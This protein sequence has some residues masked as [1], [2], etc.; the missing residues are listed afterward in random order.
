MEAKLTGPDFASS[1]RVQV[2]ACLNGILY[3]AYRWEEGGG[4]GDVANVTQFCELY[5]NYLFHP[6]AY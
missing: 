6:M 5:L 3:L 1:G 4:G 2:S